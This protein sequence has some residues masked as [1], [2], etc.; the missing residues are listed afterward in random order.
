MFQTTPTVSRGKV[1]VAYFCEI[2]TM[3]TF[4]IF[5]DCVSVC[6]S[7]SLTSV[8]FLYKTRSQRP[9]LQ[10]L[11]PGQVF[12]SSVY[13]NVFKPLVRQVSFLH[14]PNCFRSS[15]LLSSIIVS[16]S[17]IFFKVCNCM[18][19]TATVTVNS[20]NFKLEG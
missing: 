19:Q 20:A 17:L 6:L 14:E 3:S 18:L 2:D 9:I 5:S 7:T 15:Y 1:T 13:L 16:L 10:T 12:R 4:E 8:P 11:I